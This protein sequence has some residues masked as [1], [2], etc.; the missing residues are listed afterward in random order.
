MLRAQV[1]LKMQPDG[2]LKGYV[3][4]YRPWDP[5]Y[6]GWV[7]ARGTVIESLTW[8]QLPGVYYALKRNADFSP[9]G[10]GGEKTHISY[11]LRVDALPAYVMTPDATRPATEI[12]SYKAAAAPETAKPSPA[13][14]TY[15][16]AGIVP[17][18]NA[19]VQASPTAVITP[20]AGYGAG[21]AQ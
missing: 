16:S 7:N 17:D 3:G 19:K 18:K 2:S 14:T 8:V 4:G 13:A 5:V 10:A 15:V 11:A 9:M 1:N 20:P 12:V 6:K 21:G